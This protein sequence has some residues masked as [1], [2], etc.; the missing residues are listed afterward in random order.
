M[1]IIVNV[2]DVGLHPAVER[3]IG[4]LKEKGV[5]TACS[6]KANEK[7]AGVPMELAGLDIGIHLDVLRGRPVRHWQHVATLC[8]NN[9]AFLNDPAVL[10]RQYAV[11]K[12]DHAHV[13]MEW[14]EQIENVL[15]LGVE[16]THLTSHKHVHGWP[17]LA[18]IA[19]SL[20]KEYGIDWIRKP[21]E[22]SEIAKLDKSGF[23]RKFQNVCGFFDR[24]IDEIGWTD[25]MWGAPEPESFSPYAFASAV[26]REAPQDA[27]IVEL[28]CCPGMMIG[29][30]D[31][32][33]YYENP[34]K[35][36]HRWRLEYRSLEEDDWLG[37]LKKGARKLCGFS[38]LSL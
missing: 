28:R 24:E 13:E 34:V 4:I 30:D 7:L 36:A 38:E 12:V 9:G 15:S 16:P 1:Q 22:C 32:I 11:G 8:D 14:R 27:E 37:V 21:E 26:E 3:A 6:I 23:P 33:P 2:E 29:G 10:F 5:I 17:S 20:A 31:A 25:W 19:A 35:L 18:R